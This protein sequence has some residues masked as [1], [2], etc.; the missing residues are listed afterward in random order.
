MSE[1][2]GNPSHLVSALLEPCCNP[3]NDLLIA[4]ALVDPSGGFVPLRLANTSNFEKHIYKNSGLTVCEECPDSI[5]FYDKQKEGAILKVT[6]CEI[7]NE[8][9]EH[10]VKLIEASSENLT[11]DQGVAFRDLL[12]RQKDAFAKSKDNLSSTD[13]IIYKLSVGDAVPIKQTP[14][15]LPLSG[16]N[17]QLCLLYLDDVLIFSSD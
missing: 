10:L 2:V 6:R 13:I 1:I 4:K 9:P 7:E 11:L 16:L 3:D 5:T 14:R 12:M 8:L 17:W 15:R